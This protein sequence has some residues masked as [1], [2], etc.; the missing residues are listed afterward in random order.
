MHD[1]YFVHPFVRRIP[2]RSIQQ[3]CNQALDSIV[4]GVK[5]LEC[6]YAFMLL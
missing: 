6:T 1:I 3:W 5:A 2:L 4:L